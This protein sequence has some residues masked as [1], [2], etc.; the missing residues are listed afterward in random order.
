MDV[1]LRRISAE[2]ACFGLVAL[3]YFLYLFFAGD[4]RFDSDSAR[5]WDVSNP[6]G[7]ETGGYALPLSS[8]CGRVRLPGH[9][10]H[11]G[12]E[13]VRCFTRSDAR[14]R[15]RSSRRARAVYEGDHL[16]DSRVALNALVFVYWRG[17]FGFPLSD[18]PALLCASA[19]LLGLLRGTTAGYVGA[20]FG[21]MLA[22]NIRPAYFP[23]AAAAIV[24]AGLFPRQGRDPRQ[25]MRAVG[26][27]LAGAL[28]ASLPQMLINQRH[29]G[30]WNPLPGGSNEISMLQLTAGMLNQKYETYV[31]ST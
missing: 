23:A 17:H 28:V 13:G 21:F 20:G 5:Y 7:Q 10:R 15:R 30:T 6:L 27:V 12:G 16:L 3:T 8:R 26:L 1:R 25:R 14:R 29:H 11:N 19:A 24:V 22:A 4:D 18:F 9:G 2:L 31:W